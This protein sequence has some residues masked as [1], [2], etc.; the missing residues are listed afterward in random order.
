MQPDHLPAEIFARI[1]NFLVSEGGVIKAFTYRL[2][3]KFFATDS[4][5]N[6]IAVYQP[7]SAFVLPTPAASGLDWAMDNLFD[8]HRPALVRERVRNPNGISSPLF[9]QIR[10]AAQQLLG[11]RELESEALLQHYL[12]GVCA[13]VAANLGKRLHHLLFPSTQHSMGNMAT[14]IRKQAGSLLLHVAV[15]IGD[16]GLYEQLSHYHMN[17]E[18]SPPSFNSVLGT[19]VGFGKLDII[20]KIFPLLRQEIVQALQGPAPAN[21]DAFSDMRTLRDLCF[22][23]QG[24]I[25]V[26][27]RAHQNM[28]GGLLCTLMMRCSTF[29]PFIV[30]RNYEQIM[31]C[32]Q[33]S[34]TDILRSVLRMKRDDIYPLYQW[35]IHRML[36]YGNH[37]IFED[38]F[39]D[40]SVNSHYLSQQKPLEI[41]STP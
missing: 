20:N 29:H 19:A 31:E 21:L 22:Y 6:V 28:A 14:A 40:G 13:S 36:S 8:H 37:K 32:I 38:H 24:A 33:F 16:V 1:T 23:L 12:D 27:I 7:V 18:G 35:D 11:A 5:H 17:L 41:V 25:F 15:A 2:V 30:S 9:T 34:N 10:N 39:M 26:A 3:N 4:S